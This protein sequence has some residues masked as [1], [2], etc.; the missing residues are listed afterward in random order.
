MAVYTQLTRADIDGF[1]LQ[2]DVGQLASFKGIAQGVE[3][4]N[5]LLRLNHQSAKVP[6]ILT[7][8][9]QRVDAKDLPF[10]LGFTQ[11]LAQRGIVCP[12]PIAGKDGETV[13]HLKN[14]PAALIQFLE[15][16]DSPHITPTHLSLVGDLLARMHVA[17]QDFSLT[18]KNN[19]SLYGWKELFSRYRARADEI[20]PGMQKEIADELDYLSE[21]WPADLPGGI[22]HADLFPDNVFFID[23]NTDQPQLSGVIDFYFACHDSWIY[24]LLICMNAWCFDSGHTFVTARAKAL[25]QAYQKIRPLTE[26]EKNAMPLL[27]RAASMRF[28]STRVYDWLNR[29]PGALVNPKDPMEYIAKLRFHRSIGDWKDYAIF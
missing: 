24:D 17:A 7:L 21:H 8:Y 5:Y 29:I 20:A 19:L 15:G 2:Y 18:R 26:A 13:Y 16:A 27:A 11:H 1:L 4:T 12:R 28:I 14:R 10:F 3:N 6:Y 22:V 25:M 9:E 23:G